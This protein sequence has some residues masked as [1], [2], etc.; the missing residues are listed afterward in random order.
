MKRNVA[1]TMVFA[2]NSYDFQRIS[3]NTFINFKLTSGIA[4][5]ISKHYFENYSL[6]LTLYQAMIM[7]LDEIE[8]EKQ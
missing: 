8:Q 3:T 6:I 1:G 4:L 7:T 2:I 5:N